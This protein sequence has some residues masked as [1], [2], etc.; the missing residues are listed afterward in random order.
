MNR[1]RRFAA[2]TLAALVV[3]ACAAADSPTALAQRMQKAVAAKDVDAFAAEFDQLGALTGMEQFAALNL[4]RECQEMTVHA[5]GGPADAGGHGRA[6]E[7]PRAGADRP[8]RRRHRARGQERR[9]HRPDERQPPL[10]EGRYRRY[11]IVGARLKADHLAKLK[12][13]TAQAATEEKVAK[14]IGGD[15]AWKSKATPLPAD[16]GEPG[17]VFLAE[18]KAIGAAVKAK[19]V[20]AA[21]KAGGGWNEMVFGAT[22]DGKPRAARHAPAGAAR[23]VAADHRRR[24]HPGRV[25]ERATT[26]CSSSRGRTGPATRS[27]GRSSCPSATRTG[28]WF[29][30]DHFGLIEIPKG[31]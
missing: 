17:Q 14:G 30:S 11:K 25:R 6:E 24:A 8:A 28:A 21:A 18:V 5:H 7:G 22:E 2:A 13:T 16:G 26:P 1:A 31:L 20:D 23:P 4:V 27:R 10:R 19:D 15:P 9:R 12:A 29:K 3:P